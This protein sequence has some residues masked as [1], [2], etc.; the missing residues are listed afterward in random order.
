M[1]VFVESP[2]PSIAMAIVVL[3]VAYALYVN[4]RNVKRLFILLGVAAA[5]LVGGLLLDYCI[6]TDREKINNVLHL[7]AAELVNDNLE[8]VKRYIAP[9]ADYTKGL[10]EDGMKLARLNS[11]TIRGVQIDFNNATTN[12]TATVGFRGVFYVTPRFASDFGDRDFVQRM[13]FEAVFEKI[14]GQWYATDDFSYDPSI[15]GLR[16]KN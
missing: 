3:L 14:Q 10:A 8:G 4:D 6:E 11:I 1:S 13:N 5:I 9:D 12:P 2:W 7:V 15:P 16:T